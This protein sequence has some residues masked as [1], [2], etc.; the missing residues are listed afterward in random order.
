MHFRGGPVLQTHVG[1]AVVVHAHSLGD[2]ATCLLNVPECHV[3]SVLLLE[4]PI[5]PFSRRVFIAVVVLG[6]AH[7]KTARDQA[8]YVLMA[9][10]LT[11]PVRV[12]DRI[13]VRR[14][15]RESVVR[16]ALGRR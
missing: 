14:Q 3:Q 8:V 5:D 12:M 6:H 15:C 11:T 4:N 13:A 7:W 2:R 16:G 10:V 9:A 1:P